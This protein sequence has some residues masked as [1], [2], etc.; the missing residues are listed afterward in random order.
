[1]QMGWYLRKENADITAIDLKENLVFDPKLKWFSECPAISGISLSYC[2][3]AIFLFSDI[4]KSFPCSQRDWFESS[5]ICFKMIVN[6]YFPWCQLWNVCNFVCGQM[7]AAKDND[8]PH[9]QSDSEKDLR[10]ASYFDMPKARRPQI[11]EGVM[12][13]IRMI[14]AAGRSYSVFVIT[15]NV[16]LYSFA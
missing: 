2:L 6:S 5:P 7:S 14:I 13:T 8:K 15:S 4:W 16:W 12:N 1:M 11:T 9:C 10:I 3:L